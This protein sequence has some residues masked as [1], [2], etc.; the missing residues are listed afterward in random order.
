[1]ERQRAPRNPEG[2][3][4]VYGLNACRAL[5]QG[6]AA[7]IVRVYLSEARLKE[8]GP[9]LKWCAQK[10]KAYHVLNQE[11]LEKVSQSV[12]HEGVVFVAKE[13]A[14]LNDDSLGVR[15]EMLPK[16]SALLLLDGVGNPHNVGAI[17]RVGAHFGAEIAIGPAA[18]FP[19]MTPSAARMAEGGMEH[20]TIAAIKSLPGALKMLRGAGFTLV[21]A[22]GDAKDSLYAAPLPER[23]VFAV[24]NEMDGLSDA[25]RTAADRL[26][27]IPGTGAVESLNVS[28]AAGLFLGEYWRQRKAPAEPRGPA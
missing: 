16:T 24:G 6:R 8:F 1:M 26:V 19:R 11:E 10:K 15:L 4:K 21:A 27:K 23:V 28:V 22:T 13:P 5:W 14:R 17:M 2:E 3:M 9:L 12:H 20:V 7:D 25:V 18:G